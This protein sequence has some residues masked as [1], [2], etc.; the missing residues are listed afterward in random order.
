MTTRSYFPRALSTFALIVVLATAVHA[1]PL[2]TANKP[3][4]LPGKAGGYDWMLVD[5]PLHRLYAAHKGAGTLVVLDLKTE[6]VIAMPAVGTAQGIAVDAADNKIFVGDDEEKQVVVV[7]RK[8]LAITA[9]IP[10]TG[11][12][13]DIEFDPKNG[14]VYADHDDGTEVWVINGK[15]NAIVGKVTVSGAPEYIQYDP[16]SDR[17]YQNIKTTNQ[18]QVI[19]PKLQQVVATWNT[20]PVTSP[21]GLA[22]DFAAR[23]I[24]SAGPGQA[25]TFDMKSG[26]QV[27]IAATTPGRVDQIAY[28]STRKRLYCSAAGNI[29]VLKPSA[30]GLTLLG[31]V[32]QPNGAHTLAVDPATGAV[33]VSYADGTASYLQKFT[34]AP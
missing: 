26:K 21:H 25:V 3:I 11:P 15:T 20:T 18:V 7:D 32:P 8:T 22:I 16:T 17:L 6:K 12:V 30:S 34:V 33:W 4:T 23:R 9:R 24:Y 31:N 28:D 5:A 13:D 27:G 29:S 1:A 19:N 2:L 14:M 10:V